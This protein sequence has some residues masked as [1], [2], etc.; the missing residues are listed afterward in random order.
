MCGGATLVWPA[1]RRPLRSQNH[2]LQ[3][4][5]LRHELISPSPPPWHEV[6]VCL[7]PLHT[8]VYMFLPIQGG[9]DFA[10]NC[11]CHPCAKAMLILSASFRFYRMTQ[12][13]SR[14]LSHA[15]RSMGCA[16]HSAVGARAAIVVNAPWFV[17]AY[18]SWHDCRKP[19]APEMEN[20]LLQR[21]S[22]IAAPDCVAA[23]NQD[24]ARSGRSTI[25]CFARRP[26]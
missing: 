10:L 17:F 15:L 26:S 11:A 4:R 3:R 19:E 16:D 18:V 21:Q 14:R 2:R 5:A 1:C 9:L 25:I 8:L 6:V 12:A 20:H 22:S 7:S 13:R 24:A 23:A